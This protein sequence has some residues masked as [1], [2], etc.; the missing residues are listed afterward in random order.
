MDDTMKMQNALRYSCRGGVRIE[1]VE[2]PTPEDLPE[3]YALVKVLRAG[4]CR[5]DIEITQGYID[6]YDLTLGHELLGTVEAVH[7]IARQYRDHSDK[8][9]THLAVGEGCRIAVGMRVAADINIPCCRLPS[10]TSI[11]AVTD[12]LSSAS[13]SSSSSSASSSSSSSHTSS[14]TEKTKHQDNHHAA[15]FRS[16]TPVMTPPPPPPSS[17]SS[18]CTTAAA[19]STRQHQQCMTDTEDHPC[20]ACNSGG[21]IQQRNHCPRRLCIGIHS[22]AGAFCEYMNIPIDNLHIVPAHVCDVLACFAEPLAAALRIVEQI[23]SVFHR[24]QCGRR[25]GDEQLGTVAG[26]AES[27]GALAGMQT[28]STNSRIAIIGDG[29]LGLLIAETLSILLHRDKLNQLSSY[30]P[31]SPSTQSSLGCSTWSSI[32]MFGHHAERLA[33]VQTKVKT[34]LMSRDKSRDSVVLKSCANYF[35]VCVDASGSPGGLALATDFCR[36]EGIVILK[37][38]CAC[39]EPSFNT[40]NSVVVKE[41]TMD[42]YSMSSLSTLPV[43]CGG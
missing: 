31:P 43:C 2:R 17:S 36:P 16:T 6:G 27:G 10:N 33:L 34:V 26:T 19:V 39:N 38:T 41:L 7:H 12:K 3:G 28:T 37:T 13:S 24:G 20:A 32:S 1:R 22:Y 29:K 23:P 15:S 21:K 14:S 5:T 25:G 4:I 35:D 42:A 11:S 40:F 30:P 8:Q 18:S 9:T